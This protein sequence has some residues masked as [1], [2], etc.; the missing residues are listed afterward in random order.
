[1]RIYED[2]TRIQASDSDAQLLSKVR[3][4]TSQNQRSYH[5][6]NIKVDSRLCLHILTL[7]ALMVDRSLQDEKYA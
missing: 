2:R 1:M 7:K 6:E 4:N 5:V 3:G